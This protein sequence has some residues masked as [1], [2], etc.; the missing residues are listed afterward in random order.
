MTIEKRQAKKM[1]IGKNTIFDHVS[2]DQEK[3]FSPK[4]LPQKVPKKN[5]KR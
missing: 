4:K 5:I 2:I 3:A 1:D